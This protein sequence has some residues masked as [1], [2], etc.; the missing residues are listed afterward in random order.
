MKKNK[1]FTLVKAE[2]KKN[3]LGYF[4]YQQNN[5]GGRFVV[6]ENVSPHVY[7]EANNEKEADSRAEEVGIYF[8]GGGDCPCCGERWDG[9]CDF[10][11]VEDLY[12]AIMSLEGTRIFKE[13]GEVR[14]HR[15]NGDKISIS[16]NEDEKYDGLNEWLEEALKDD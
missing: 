2:E 6:D 10:D 9:A 5:S 7:I 16:L 12:D 3:G 14:I 13:H 15:L 8:D 4:L 11:R 1:N